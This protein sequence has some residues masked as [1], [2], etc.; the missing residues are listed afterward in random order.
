MFGIVYSGNFYTPTNVDFP[1]KKIESILEALNPSL[2]ITDTQN[3]N[4]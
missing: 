2:I 1:G 3:K 4:K